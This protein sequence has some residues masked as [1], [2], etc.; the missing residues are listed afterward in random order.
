MYR[1]LRAFTFVLPAALALWPSWAGAQ[2]PIVYPPVGFYAAAESNLKIKVKPA[3]A[4]VFVDGYFA[5]RVAEYDGA[6]QRLHV[7]PGE[8][9]IVIHL[10]GFRSLRQK[11]YLSPNATRT[12][13]GTLEK[14]SPGEP[15]EPMPTPPPDAGRY[16]RQDPDQPPLRGPVP[17]RGRPAPGDPRDGRVPPDDRLG[18]RG[19]ADTPSGTLSI[20]VQPAGAT[21]L[22]D[23]ERWDGPGRADERLIVQLPEGHHRV[24]VQRDG[25]GPVVVEVDVRRGET[26]PVNVSLTRAP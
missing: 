18:R 9:E 10:E 22:I 4:Q 19:P 12:I 8:H 7:A 11:L 5:G 2:P 21:V 3:D 25:Y 6:F 26:T 1:L 17:R 14:L 23:G 15:M 20:R 24:E 13:R 16:G